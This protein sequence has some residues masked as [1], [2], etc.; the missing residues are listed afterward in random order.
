MKSFK[1]FLKVI[2]PIIVDVA[3]VHGSHARKKKAPVVVD[4]DPV[5][6]SHASKGSLKEEKFEHGDAGRAEPGVDGAAFHKKHGL[7]DRKWK[8]IDKSYTPS[9]MDYPNH[10]P[11]KSVKDYTEASAINHQLIH[12][13]TGKA[14]YLDSSHEHY[15]AKKP[16]FPEKNSLIFSQRNRQLNNQKRHLD[17]AISSNKLKSKAV[18][19][20]G[21]SFNPHEFASKHPDRHI[22]MPSYTST[23]TSSEMAADFSHPHY[24]PDKPSKDN[25]HV[26]RI[27]LPKGHEALPI[28]HRSHHDHEHEVLLHRDSKFKISEKP[29]HSVDHGHKVVHYWDAHPVK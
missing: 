21:T 9:A 27:H 11:L 5:H 25:A 10:T 4:V 12:H 23:S 20:H 17:H 1:Q 19:Y 24:N 28:L 2:A 18:V 7:S 26:L 14:S 3:P 16:K 29:T 13:A 22:H 15:L 8:H 6:G